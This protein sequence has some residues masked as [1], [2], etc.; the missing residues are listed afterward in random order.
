MSPAVAAVPS[1][2][3]RKIQGLLA[4]AKSDNLNEAAAA[5]DRAEAL[6]AKHRLSMADVAASSGQSAEQIGEGEVLMTGARFATWRV[7]LGAAIGHH[8]GCYVVVDARKK[9]LVEGREVSSQ[10]LRIMGL[11]AD[12]ELTHYMFAWISAV[13]VRL[14]APEKGR[15]AKN[16]FVLG[17]VEAITAALKASKAKVEKAHDG[18]AAIELASRADEAKRWCNKN[19]GASKTTYSSIRYDPQA[20]ERGIMAGGSIHLGASLPGGPRSLPAAPARS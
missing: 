13:V 6:I 4:L 1:D 8:Y 2:I 19:L 20:H 7:D 18:S 10:K 15:R 5:M 11:A 16:S 3:I 17:A 12:V 14:A 9:T